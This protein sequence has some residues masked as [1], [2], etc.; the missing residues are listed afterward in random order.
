[1][2]DVLGIPVGRRLIATWREWLMPV[3]QPYVVPR[4]VADR[5]GL[6]DERDRLTSELRDAFMLYGLKDDRALC[7]LT[8][9]ESRRLPQEVRRSQTTA[10]RWPRQEENDVARVVRFVEHGRRPSRHLDVE[11][12]TWR[13]ASEYLPGARALAGTF[14]ARSGPNC[15]G[16]V[17][18]AAGIVGVADS[19]LQREPFEDWLTAATRE[20]GL[21]HEPGTVLV[22]RGDDGSVQHAAVTLGDGW[23]LHKPSQGWMSPTKVLG[24][25]DAKF[26]SRSAG[27]HL[28]RRRITR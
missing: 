2:V 1:M 27:L 28:Q 25:A 14:P 7:W 4:P 11:E 6:S 19:W 20:G 22:W 24:V 12:S 5:L 9:P 26:S 8:R 10:H 13:R 23:A 16:A 17:M 3:E 18:G 21:D 15:F